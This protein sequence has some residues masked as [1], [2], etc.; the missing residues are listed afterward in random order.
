MRV[1]TFRRNVFVFTR[2]DATFLKSSYNLVHPY[3]G[4]VQREV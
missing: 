1:Q 3:M 2:C 4:C